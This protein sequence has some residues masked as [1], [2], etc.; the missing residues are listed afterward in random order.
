MNSCG[1]KTKK[2]NAQITDT[3]QYAKW[4]RQKRGILIAGLLQDNS[5]DN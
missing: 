4:A 3:L 2:G 5:K 1:H